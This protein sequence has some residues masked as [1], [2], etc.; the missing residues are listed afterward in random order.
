MA[1]TQQEVL[2]DPRVHKF[3][4]TEYYKLSDLGIFDDKRVELIEGEVIDRYQEPDPRLH[5]WT[6]KEYY[7]MAEAGLFAD[8]HVELID[9]RI[10]E[11]SALNRPHVRA[12]KKAV[13]IFERV[14]AEG[15]FV[16]DQ[17]PLNL[18]D[19]DHY[20]Q[21]EPY[22]AVIKG[23]EDDYIE[24]FPTHAALVLEVSFA[25]LR[26][27]R[28]KKASLYAK[29]RIPEYWILNLL[30]RQLEVFRQ[31]VADAS[32]PFWFSY[33]EKLVFKDGESVSPLAKP[34]ALV[35]VADLIPWPKGKEPR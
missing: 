11:M 15:Y 3:D 31:P 18:D 29:A 7:Q 35:N 12:V 9:G 14:F 10:I 33:A 21:P 5:I 1:T 24:E 26:F 32:A 13:R 28:E 25:T 6:S 17:A 34:E 30:Q 23:H 4:V 22:V 16:Q 19:L 20:S 8:K 27:D 2:N